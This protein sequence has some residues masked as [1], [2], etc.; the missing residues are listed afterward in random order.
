MGDA[1]REVVQRFI[2]AHVEKDREAGARLLHPEYVLSWPQ[3]GEL[4]RGPA[5]WRAVFENYPDDDQAAVTSGRILGSEDRWALT[6][7]F[8]L[9][10]ISGEGD[11]Y[12]HE[13]TVRYPN[14][15][16]WRYVAILEIRDR[17]IWRET[18]YFAPPFEAPPWRS[19]WVEKAT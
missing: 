7:T 16:V 18:D 14:G 4:I 6:P 13:G 15:E 10:R 19:Q 2:D 9:L 5:N 3:S 11:T 8:T 1:E 12:T 17:K